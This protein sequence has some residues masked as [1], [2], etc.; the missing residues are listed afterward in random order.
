MNGCRKNDRHSQQ[1]LFE[2]LKEYAVIIC[3]RYANHV[4]EVQDLV[5]DGF[6][7]VYKNINHYN[8]TKFG[9]SEAAFKGWFK[10]VIINNCI[11][12]LK[13]HHQPFQT[14]SIEDDSF[15]KL[16]AKEVSGADNLNYKDVY[17]SVL[18]LPPVY[19]TVFCLFAIDGYSHEEIA[20]YLGISVGTSKSNLFKAR[21]H[22]KKN[23]LQQP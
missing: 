7:K 6:M 9:L 16:L 11:N 3:Y 4:T 10:R 17:H 1:L 21:Q 18:Q 19:K 13:V 12:Y 23:V 22:L 20:G 5:S 15:L 8:E 14:D 2:W